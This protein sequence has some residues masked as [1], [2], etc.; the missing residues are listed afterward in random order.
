MER[1]DKAAELASNGIEKLFETVS[2]LLESHWSGSRAPCQQRTLR[3]ELRPWGWLS[4]AVPFYF[5]RT[6]NYFSAFRRIVGIAALSQPT[7]ICIWSGGMSPKARPIAL[8]G[9]LYDTVAGVANVIPFFVIFAK[10]VVPLVNISETRTPHPPSLRSVVIPSTIPPEAK[11]SILTLATNGYL[12]R[13]PFLES[14]E[15]NDTSITRG[16]SVIRGPCNTTILGNSIYRNRCNL[17]VD[18]L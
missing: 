7:R 10:T 13:L 8:D 18:I 17:I 2:A 4:R 9:R 3:T 14:S 5:C 16:G 6:F 11:R 12:A 15:S 1:S